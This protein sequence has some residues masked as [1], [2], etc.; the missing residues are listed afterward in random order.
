MP[1]FCTQMGP[2]IWLCKHIFVLVMWLMQ[3]LSSSCE[4]IHSYESNVIVSFGENFSPKEL[5]KNSGSYSRTLQQACAL[6]PHYTGRCDPKTDLFVLRHMFGHQ[7]K[8][9]KFNSYI[10]EKVNTAVPQSAPVKCHMRCTWD[11]T[12]SGTAG[13]EDEPKLPLLCVSECAACKNRWAPRVCTHVACPHGKV[14]R[15]SNNFKN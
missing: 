4:T 3:T 10:P 11:R 9:K 2:T 6:N 14:R 8:K 13:A 1:D 15:S 5:R 7:I 12:W